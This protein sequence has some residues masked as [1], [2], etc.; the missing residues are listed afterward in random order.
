MDDVELACR[1]CTD[2]TDHGS[3]QASTP[4]NMRYF[5]FWMK[6][7]TDEKLLYKSDFLVYVTR[8]TKD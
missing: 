1:A 7:E 6:D 8:Q 2:E 3:G 4:A 5:I